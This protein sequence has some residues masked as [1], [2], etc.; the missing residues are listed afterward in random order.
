MTKKVFSLLLCILM[1]VCLFSC[2]KEEKTD[3]VYATVNGEEIMSREIEYF[4]SKERANVIGEY[5]QKYDITIAEDFWSQEYDGKTPQQ[6]LDR[7]ALEKAVEAKIK[8]VQMKEQG[9]YDD[10]S[11]NGLYRRAVEFNK[12]NENAQGV[13]GVK[14]IDLEQFYTYYIST[15]EMELENLLSESKLKPSDEEVSK[16]AET[17]SET[18][19]NETQDSINRI[20]QS[21]VASDKYEKYISKLISE[22]VVEIR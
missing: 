12:K 19:K 15:G 11:Y 8:L 21:K 16:Y 10:I 22:A 4:S 9:I 7:R 3:E 1:S 13:V 20:A 5:M 17:Y 2:G 6:E 18:L 14:T